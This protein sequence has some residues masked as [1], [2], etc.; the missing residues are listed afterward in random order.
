MQNLKEVIKKYCKDSGLKL[1]D[2]RRD[3]L[4]LSLSLYDYSSLNN[5]F[6]KEYDLKTKEHK[7]L[8]ELHQFLV[9]TIVDFI[10]E[11]KGIQDMIDIKREEIKKKILEETGEPFTPDLRVYFGI[12]VLEESIKQKKWVPSTDSSLDICLGIHSVIKSA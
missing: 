4:D 10:S 8:F 12:D 3:L 6:G 5:N 1:I 2:I 11:N 7:E 9:Q